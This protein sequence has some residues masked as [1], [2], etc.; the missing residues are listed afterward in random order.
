M[1]LLQSKDLFDDILLFDPQTSEKRYLKRSSSPEFAE[2]PINGSFAIL[3][4]HCLMLYRVGSELR[5]SIDE[6]T[7]LIKDTTLSI[8]EKNR[9]RGLFV[10]QDNAEEKI[11]FKYTLTDLPQAIP[12]DTTP[13]VAAED[14]DF[15]QFVYNVLNNPE[16]RSFIYQ[17]L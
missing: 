4:G 14:F 8:L 16:R 1:I 17:V 2:L 10:L 5:F 13:H 12:G 6:Q 15:C 7:I 3:A 11:R 9:D